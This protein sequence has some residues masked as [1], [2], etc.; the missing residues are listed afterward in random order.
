MSDLLEAE[1]ALKENLEMDHRPVQSNYLLATVYIR[2]GRMLEA[3]AQFDLPMRDRTFYARENNRYL[4][5][6]AMAAAELAIAEGRWTEAI[7]ASESAIAVFE[8]CGYR[9]WWARQ[10]IDLGDAYIGRDESGDLERARESYQ[11]SLDMFTE[12]GAP[13][14][15]QVLE[16]RLGKM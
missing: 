10:L 14:Y 3:H 4:A 12:M 1:S 6:R 5:S 11:Q 13:G 15:I 8:A 2:Q 9:L 16:Q 7:A